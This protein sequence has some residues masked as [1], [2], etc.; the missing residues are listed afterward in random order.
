MRPFGEGG[1][2]VPACIVMLSYLHD[3]LPPPPVAIDSPS[4]EELSAAEL[5]MGV[6]FI[7]QPD[8]RDYARWYPDAAMN[9]GVEGRVTM[10]CLIKADGYLRC[11]IANDEPAGAGFGDAALQISTIFRVPPETAEGVATAGRRIRRTIV[12]RLAS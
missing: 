2:L 1:P 9:N 7:E 12:F 6:Q 4:A 3:P 5:V 11:A 8:G 10:D